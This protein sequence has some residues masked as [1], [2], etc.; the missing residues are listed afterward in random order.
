MNGKVHYS[1]QVINGSTRDEN[2]VTLAWMTIIRGTVQL[3]SS[4]I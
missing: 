2:C 1:N 4:Q 3:L